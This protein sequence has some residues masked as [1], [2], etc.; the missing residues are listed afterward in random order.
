MVWYS[1]RTVS[2]C[3]LAA[4]GLIFAAAAGGQR[5]VPKALRPSEIVA[6]AEHL[7]DGA[8]ASKP[9]RQKLAS[10]IEA[11]YLTDGA[12]VLSVSPKQWSVLTGGHRVS[13]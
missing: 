8:K 5:P 10:R 12:A 4:F 13:P 7:R 9:A 1:V 2:A 6:L 11:Q 3:L